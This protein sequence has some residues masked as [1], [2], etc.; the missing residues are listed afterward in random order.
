MAKDNLERLK[1][2]DFHN[3]EEFI[4]LR[5]ILYSSTLCVSRGNNVTSR[6]IVPILH[7]LEE[8][9]TEEDEDE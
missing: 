4:D 5:K 3:A 6:Q 1:D 9:F 7:K 8:H 2:E